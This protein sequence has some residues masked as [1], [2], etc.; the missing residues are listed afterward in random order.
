MSTWTTGDNEGEK[1]ETR[2]QKGITWSENKE[3][4]S[5]IMQDARY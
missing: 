2:N 5:Y 1:K 4:Q 3:K